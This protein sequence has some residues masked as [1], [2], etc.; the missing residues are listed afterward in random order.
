MMM[1]SKAITVAVAA[2]VALIVSWTWGLA[3]R[4]WPI[5]VLSGGDE[6][7]VQ[8]ICRVMPHHLVNP[9]S[10]TPSPGQ[11]LTLAWLL[12]ETKVRMGVIWL[13]WAVVLAV[14]IMIRKKAANQASHATSEPA[15][16]AASSA[17]E[18]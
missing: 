16:G 10:I 6:S 15:P 11:D 3:L 9:E 18:G 17:R 4:L 2:L 5:S 8:I 14:V 12:Q 1:K 13:L 7:E